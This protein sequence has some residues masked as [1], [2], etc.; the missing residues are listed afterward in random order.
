MQG[1]TSARLARLARRRPGPAR[2]V[3]AGSLV[4]F[5]AAIGLNGC[6][7]LNAIRKVVQTVEANRALINEFS[8][9]LRAGEKVAFEATY[10]TTGGAP[11]TVTYAVQPPDEVAFREVPDGAGGLGGLNGS[12]NLL[13]NSTGGYSCSPGNGSALGT[14]W[15]CT[16]LG[17]AKQVERSGVVDIYTPA[18]WAAFLGVVAIAAGLAGDSV[19]SF[20]KDV[21]GFELDCI[22]LHVKGVAGTSTLCTTAQGILGYV[23]VAGVSTSFELKAYSSTPDASLFQLPAGAKVVAPQPA[24]TPA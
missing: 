1:T 4:V 14:G 17:S 15:T 20:T 7:V 3:V 2:R 12:Y 19:R 13:A 24:T 23:Q 22:G 16:K 5:A 8:K 6:G 11:V 18:H 9:G 21:N 10:V